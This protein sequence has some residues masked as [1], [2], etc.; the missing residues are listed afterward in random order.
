VGRKRPNRWGL[1]DLHGNVFEWCW[2]WYGSYEKTEELA[3]DP[4]GPSTGDDRVL[5][6]GSFD[7]PARDLR[8]AFRG[9]NGPGGA[10]WDIGFR[11]VRSPRRQP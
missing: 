2:D 11:C 5:R 6:G 1:H 7:Y 8:S 10:G 3:A 9:V 4:T